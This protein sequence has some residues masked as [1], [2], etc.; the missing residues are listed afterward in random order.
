M[1]NIEIKARCQNLKKARS[2]AEKIQTEYLGVL[3]QIDTY[4]VTK[5]GR[6]KLREIN[7]QSAQLIP[8]V[9]G[10]KA[11]PM[12]SDYALLNVDNP[13]ILKDLLNQLLGIEFVVD[14]TREVFIFENVRI[15]LDEVAGL[16][17]F[18]E[19]EA[20]CANDSQE[21]QKIQQNKILSLMNTFDIGTGDLLDLSYVDYLAPESRRL[22]APKSGSFQDRI[23]Q[24]C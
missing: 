4:F 21:E 11:G 17:T 16:G 3:R 8:Y 18:I 5:A 22:G 9:K 23:P 12:K 2:T 13:I 1:P 20:V 7:N 15:H 19:F 10:Y 6:L 24:N 14:K